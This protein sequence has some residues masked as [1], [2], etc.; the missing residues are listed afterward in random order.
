MMV[1]Y[2]L[3]SAIIVLW[4]AYLPTLAGNILTQLNIVPTHLTSAASSVNR[5]D[6]SDQ[7]ASVRFDDRWR[8]FVAM[9]MQTLGENG[10]NAGA[11]DPAKVKKVQQI[12][13]GCES[14]FG[15]LVK[16]GNFSARC[17]AAVDAAMRLAK[18]E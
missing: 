13:V 11:A 4:M 7:L 16:A 10:V 3:A 8:A 14:A 12:P 15:Y 6:K 18:A 5:L 2:G 17:I 1:V 9:T